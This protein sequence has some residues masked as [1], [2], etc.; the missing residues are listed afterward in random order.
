MDNLLIHNEVLKIA[1]FGLAKHLA[2]GDKTGSLIG[3]PVNMA[4]EILEGKPYTSKVDVYSLGVIFYN[5]LFDGE[6]PFHGHTIKE[7]LG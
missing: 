1:D 2:E 6:Y 4:P 7:L 5:I 3:T